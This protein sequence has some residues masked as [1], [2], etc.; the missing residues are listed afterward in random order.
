MSFEEL[1]KQA[2]LRFVPS[3]WKLN[4]SCAYVSWAPPCNEP[5]FHASFLKQDTYLCV[6]SRAALCAASNIEIHG[7]LAGWRSTSLAGVS[8]CL[9]GASCWLAGAFLIGWSLFLASRIFSWLAGVSSWL[10]GVSS[11]LAGVSFWPAGIFVSWLAGGS[12][13]P[14]SLY[15]LFKAAGLVPYFRLSIRVP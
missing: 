7:F 2:V 10:A 5:N 13:L 15:C 4:N 9:A 12:I 1:Y 14:S 6:F 8:F 11:W 3:L